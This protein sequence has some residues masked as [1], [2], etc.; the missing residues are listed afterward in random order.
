MSLLDPKARSKRGLAI[1]AEVAGKPAPAAAT[2]HEES[3][4]DF[5]FAE[6]WERPGLDKR[7]RYLD[8]KSVV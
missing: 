3:W 7:A 1:Q 2:P 5:V 6:V 8:R 4:R